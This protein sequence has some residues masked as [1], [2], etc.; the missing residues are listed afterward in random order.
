MKKA[1]QTLIDRLDLKECPHGIMQLHDDI[2]SREVRQRFSFNRCSIGSFLGTRIPCSPGVAG[3]DQ[4]VRSDVSE[5]IR[6]HG[7]SLCRP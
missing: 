4:R 6:G 5:R 1:R 2:V 7:V 3:I